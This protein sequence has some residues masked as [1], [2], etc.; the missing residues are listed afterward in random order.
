MDIFG[1]NWKNHPGKIRQSWLSMI[2]PEDTVIIA[3]DLSWGRNLTDALPDLQWLSTLPGRKIIIR[4]NHD[5]WW[6]TVTKMTKATNGAFEFLHNNTIKVGSI[7]LAGTRSW[8]PETARTFTEK[9]AAILKRE[10]GRLE[11]SLQLAAET[12][13][14]RIFCVLH[15]P[16]YDDHRRP[17]HILSIMKKYGVQD[18]IFG[19]IHGERNFH[20]LPAELCGIRLHLTSAD[21]LDFKPY[22]ICEVCD[23]TKTGRKPPSLRIHLRGSHHGRIRVFSR[24]RAGRSG[25]YGSV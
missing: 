2:R 9:D 7:A 21:Y 1:A 23:D 11:R 6:D 19:H 4:G 5:Y 15:Y 16:P 22:F 14:S 25:S 18:C 24:K 3:G 20:D 13:A 17:M 12:G 10:E 8:I